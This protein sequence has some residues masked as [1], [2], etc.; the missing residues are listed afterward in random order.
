MCACVRVW[1]LRVC[2]CACGLSV[3]WGGTG[4]HE[5]VVCVCVAG[6]GGGGGGGGGRK[7]GERSF[8]QFTELQTKKIQQSSQ[9]CS[10]HLLHAPAL[11]GF[12]RRC[13]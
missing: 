9:P 2:V 5:C 12:L 1:R 10:L 7:E 4:V 13:I 8:L 6:G 11:V 3:P